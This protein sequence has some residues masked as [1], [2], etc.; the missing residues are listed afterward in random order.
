MRLIKQF[1]IPLTLLI[2]LL[3]FSCD[4]LAASKFDIDAGV[5]AATDPFKQFVQDHWLACIV[6][7]CCFWFGADFQYHGRFTPFSRLCCIV[8]S[9]LILT[10]A[11]IF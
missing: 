3:A 2:I 7:W 9:V 11:F 5:K 4:I 1:F 8:G 6:S 10:Y